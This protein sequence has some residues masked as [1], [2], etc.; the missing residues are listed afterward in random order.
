[1]DNLNLKEWDIGDICIAKKDLHY[2]SSGTNSFT[3]K[4]Q[5][6]VYLGYSEHRDYF[7]FCTVDRYNFELQNGYDHSIEFEIILEELEDFV[8]RK[9]DRRKRIIKEICK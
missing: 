3:T 2:K 9:I 7:W 5:L 6:L 8:E 4:G 1:M